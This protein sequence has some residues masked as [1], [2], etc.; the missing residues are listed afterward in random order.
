MQIII[1][2]GELTSEPP[3]EEKKE[4]K[5]KKVKRS[6]YVGII[7]TFMALL[8]AGLSALSVWVH[9]EKITTLWEEPEVV[10]VH[11]HQYEH[12]VLQ[13]ATCTENGRVKVAC[14]DC[15]YAWE[16]SVPAYGH[17]LEVN[18]CTECGLRASDGLKFTLR[19]DEE[20]FSYAVILGRGNCP[21]R[22]VVIPNV[23]GGLPVREI[24]ERAFYGDEN[25][26]TV[27]LS[28]TVL[29]VGDQAFAEC[30]N[31][32]R[33]YLSEEVELGEEVF[34]H[35]HYEKLLLS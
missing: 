9:W 13:N 6:P 20:G 23:I 30:K 33:V 25:L 22:D 7:C 34:K 8:L 3:K 17:H 1:Q 12:T 32:Y 28:E 4:I 16:V 21:D 10:E 31:L 14:F 35:T 27:Q 19:T 11:T 26:Y 5:E 2:R 18:V 29:T 24:A 15:S